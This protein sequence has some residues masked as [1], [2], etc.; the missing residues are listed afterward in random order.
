MIMATIVLLEASWVTMCSTSMVSALCR[1][2]CTTMAGGDVSR[3]G[4][5]LTWKCASNSCMAGGA[6]LPVV[7]G[8]PIGARWVTLA[9]ALVPHAACAQQARLSGSGPPVVGAPSC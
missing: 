1:P 5:Q 6:A 2:Q 3:T 4:L 9:A 8:L 7:K